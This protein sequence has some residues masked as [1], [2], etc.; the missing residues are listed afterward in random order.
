MEIAL[1]VLQEESSFTQGQEV[2]EMLSEGNDL[3]V[4]LTYDGGEARFY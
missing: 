2:E 3:T 1:S 4:E